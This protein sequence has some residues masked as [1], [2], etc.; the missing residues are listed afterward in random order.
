MKCISCGGEISFSDRVCPYCGRE[1]K[2]TAEH[3]A[4]MEKYKKENE[5][6]K[7]KLK[8]VIAENMPM[9]ISAVVML[10]LIIV[11]CAQIYISENAYHFREDALRRESVKKYD[12]YSAQIKNYL[13]AGDYTGFDAFAEYHN[14][15][16]YEEPY[17]DLNLLCEVAHEY[18]SLVSV[19][20]DVL[21]YGEDAEI[22]NTDSDPFNCRMAIDDLYRVFRYKEEEIDKDPYRDYMYDMK[23]KADIILEIYFGL[24]EKERE[25]FLESSANEQEAYL[26]EVIFDD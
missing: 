18:T 11:A 5:K 1:L 4:D 14:I 17:D 23:K 24:D 10:L 3:R 22:Y 9:V 20:E 12:E 6:T 7:R 2:E 21:I 15:A 26:E 8:Q 13:E 25:E 16:E 19:A